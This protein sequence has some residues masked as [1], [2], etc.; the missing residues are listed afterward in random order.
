MP[1]SEP[2]ESWT[3]IPPAYTLTRSVEVLVAIGKTIHVV[4]SS[5]SED[6]MLQDGPFSHICVSPNGKF[7]SLYTDDGRVWV[8]SSDF[9]D[10]LSEYN[11]RVK[12]PPKDMQWCGNDSV[13]LAW[14]DEVHMVGPSGAAS[15]Y[16]L[17]P[18]QVDQNP[19]LTSA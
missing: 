10:K 16:A 17:K 14:D 4:D 12:T 15:K 13:V 2:V 5:D 19:M 6:R 7:I 1:P 11:S 18:C 9:Q 8:I 3:V